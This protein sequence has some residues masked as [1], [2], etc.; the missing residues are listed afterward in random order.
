VISLPELNQVYCGFV[1]RLPGRV[2]ATA[3][4]PEAME[5]GWFTEQEMR[6]LDNW[7]P[8]GRIDVGIQFAF[9]RSRVFEFIQQ[10]DSFM[11]LISP[12]GIRYL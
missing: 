2:M 11:R 1:A 10:T 3:V 7:D 6:A 12:D 9:F 4:P 5:V 8:A